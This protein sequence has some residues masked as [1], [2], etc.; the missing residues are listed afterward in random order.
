MSRTQTSDLKTQ[1]PQHLENLDLETADTPQPHPSKKKK[2]KTFLTRKLSSPKI[3][4]ENSDPQTAVTKN[5]VFFFLF[6]DWDMALMSSPLIVKVS[7]L[8]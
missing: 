2:R 3:W 7:K 6:L 4:L 1:R 8:G 5:D